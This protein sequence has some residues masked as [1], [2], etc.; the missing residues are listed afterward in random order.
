VA[1]SG[2]NN[3]SV[4]DGNTNSVIATVSVGTSP[5]GVGVNPL[6]NGIYVANFNSNNVSVIAGNINSVIATI[7]VGANPRGVGVNP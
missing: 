4:I 7:P 3:V 5:E 6:T 2:S 1:N